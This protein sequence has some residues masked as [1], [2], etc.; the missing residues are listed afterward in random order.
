MTHPVEP[1]QPHL[2]KDQLELLKFLREESEQNRKAQR[3]ESDANRK[4]FLDTS[5]VVAIPLAVL[6][7][8]SGIFFYR[9]VNTMKEAM[10]TEAESEA[11][12]EI[13]RMD[14]HIDQTLEDRF[15]ADNIQRTI[16]QAALDA[17]TKQAP[18]LIKEV[19]TPEVRKAVQSES[20]TI[21]AVATEAATNEVRGSVGP[22][23]AD[24]KL[25]A[26]IARATSD[27]A[28]SFDDLLAFRDSGSGTPSQKEL[29]NSVVVNLERH[30]EE[31]TFKGGYYADCEDPSGAAYRGLLASPLTSVRKS[32]MSTCIAFMGMGQWAPK[33]QG[34]YESAFT[35]METIAPMWMKLAVSDPSLSVRAQAVTGMNWL[36]R[37]GQDVPQNGFDL[38]DT[39]WLRRWWAKHESDQAA[40][41]L[42]AFTE[43]QVDLSTTGRPDQ[44]RLDQIGLYDELGRL[45]KT[46]ARNRAMLE[47]VQEQMRSYAATARYSPPDLA[48]QMGR[49]CDGVKQDLAI[50]LK[51]FRG[52]P[53]QE[54]VDGYGLLELQFLE[55]SCVVSGELLSQIADYGVATRSLSSRYAAVKIVNKASG[56]SLDPYQS[57]PLEVWIESHNA[58]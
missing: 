48:R 41:A 44:S 29:V 1:Q 36:F 38:L 24:V 37:G 55:G 12:A 40:I 11:R 45:A 8:L 42:A 57:K 9:D 3:E 27:D 46:S 7:T 33:I 4:L 6:L 50:R 5:K 32:A 30:A 31:G 53:E 23:I 13:K 20:G 17:T 25:Q 10:K 26:M 52:Q 51:S 56:T 54:R 39:T 18:D 14:E 19:I 16:Q 15:K 28:R 21:R 2:S 43:D 47:Q 58:N 22:I 49:G 34:K 35:V